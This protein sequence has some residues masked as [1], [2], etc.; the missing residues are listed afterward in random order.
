MDYVYLEHVL[1]PTD[2]HAGKPKLVAKG[3]RMRNRL[4]AAD[5]A[6]TI[7][8]NHKGNEGLKTL[9]DLE[10]TSLWAITLERQGAGKLF[11]ER[12]DT[13]VVVRVDLSSRTAGVVTN[14]I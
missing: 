14:V 3:T 6:A 11:V 10:N 5:A 13:I 12:N 2:G 1:C 8:M 7:A 9:L 4:S